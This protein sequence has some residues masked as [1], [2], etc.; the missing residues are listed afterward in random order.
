MV[1]KFSPLPMTTVDCSL[2]FRKIWPTL[3]GVDPTLVSNTDCCALPEI[4]CFGDRIIEV[5]IF[6]QALQGQIPSEIGQLSELQV[7]HLYRNSITGRIPPEIGQ[8]SKLK[9]LSLGGNLLNGEIP[10]EMGNLQSLNVMYLDINQLTGRIPESLGNLTNMNTLFLQNNLLNGPLPPKLKNLNIPNLKFDDR[11]RD[12]FV[13]TDSVPGNGDQ[14][15]AM[16]TTTLLLIIAVAVIIAGILAVVSWFLV[17]KRTAKN[18]VNLIDTNAGHSGINENPIIYEIGPESIISFNSSNI[19]TFSQN[20][21]QANP[22]PPTLLNRFPRCIIFLAQS[23]DSLG[24]LM[25]IVEY[26]FLQVNVK[27]KCKH[28]Y[29]P[30]MLDELLINPNDTILILKHT[31]DGWAYGQNLTSGLLGI[32]PLACTFP[33]NTET[34]IILFKDI[35]TVVGQE[36]ELIQASFPEHFAIQEYTLESLGV[37]LGEMYGTMENALV[38]KDSVVKYGPV[39]IYLSGDLY[40]LD[41]TESMIKNIGLTNLDYEIVRLL[42]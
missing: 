13:G 1:C 11:N 38:K 42:K 34:R 19:D 3:K 33:P 26:L 20:S 17:K 8:L 30:Q 29:V 18:I 31:R 32:F 22:I 2:Y 10:T 36:M 4:K 15:N 24:P 23:N 27:V 9:D 6:S 7:L 5:R 39:T 25:D 21:G 28:E 40:Y 41:N 37:V 16:P 14:Q 35:L 12:D